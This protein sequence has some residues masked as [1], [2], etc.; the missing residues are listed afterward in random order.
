[1]NEASAGGF[2]P[3]LRDLNAGYLALVIGIAVLAVAIYA[4]RFRT[5]TVGDVIPSL[6][7]LE[8]IATLTAFA[9][10][11]VALIATVIELAQ[12]AHESDVA[13]PLRAFITAISSL[14]WAYIFII[15][16]FVF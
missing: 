11:V 2:W 16:S 13:S 1:M 5:D 9:L 12:M 4:L 8:K 14:H 3:A 10:I 6:D 15:V 7:L